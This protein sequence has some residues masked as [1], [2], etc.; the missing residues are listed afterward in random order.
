MVKWRIHSEKNNI[1]IVIKKKGVGKGI[2]A[3]NKIINE[4]DTHI[5]MKIERRKKKLK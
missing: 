5:K 1:K 3:G 2:D 4:N